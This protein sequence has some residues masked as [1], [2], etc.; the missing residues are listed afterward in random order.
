MVFM[1]KRSLLFFTVIFLLPIFSEITFRNKKSIRLEKR[2]SPVCLKTSIIIPCHYTHFDFLEEILFAHTK[3]TI[4]PD[5][6]IVSLSEAHHIDKERIQTLENHPWPFEVKILCTNEK[7]AAGE[8]RNIACEKVTGDLVIC[9]DADDLPHNRRTELVKYFFEN[10][11]INCL[12]HLY[13]SDESNFFSKIETRKIRSNYLKD[14]KKFTY[15]GF[16]AIPHAHIC[17]LRDLFNKVQWPST[18]RLEDINFNIEVFEKIENIALLKLP[19]TLYRQDLS[20][21]KNFFSE[22]EKMFHIELFSRD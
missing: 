1:N 16:N 8:N 12:F 10:Y 19:L 22:E 2:V 11:Q 7:K 20:T 18:Y 13:S 17:F 9:I 6:I 5:E 15:H 21:W 3:Q 14:Y 4:L